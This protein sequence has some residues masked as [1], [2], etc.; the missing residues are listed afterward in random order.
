MSAITQK[1]LR[2]TSEHGRKN[3]SDQSKRS[4][5][6]QGPPGRANGGA[7]QDTPEDKAQGP[8]VS[9]LERDEQ[10]EAPPRVGRPPG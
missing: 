2:N 7:M 8:P 4:T 3:I 5:Q 9:L 10:G 1:G 6:I